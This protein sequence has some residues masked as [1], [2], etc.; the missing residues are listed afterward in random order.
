MKFICGNLII[1]IFI[2]G[3]HEIKSDKTNNEKSLNSDRVTAKTK[4]Y[5]KIQAFAEEESKLEVKSVSYYSKMYFRK[6]FSFS[7]P[8]NKCHEENCQYC[9][10]SLNF[11]GSKEQCENSNHTMNILKIM[12]F[13]LCTILISCLIYK[14]YITDSEPEHQDEDKIDDNTLNLLIGLFIQNRENRR[15]FKL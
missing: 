9:C 14:I 7:T 4:T 13:S 10:L 8:L 6:L 2:C 12:F 3:V 1:F 5:T 15:K 11:C